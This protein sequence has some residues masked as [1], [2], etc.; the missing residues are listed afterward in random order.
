M[1]EEPDTTDPNGYTTGDRT[2]ET[3][4]EPWV[5][6]GRLPPTSW[7]IPGGTL[8]PGASV[9]TFTVGSA[10]IDG[11][12]RIEYDGNLDTI[13]RLN[14]SGALDITNATVD[15][16]NLTVA[17]LNGGPHIFATYGSLTG[18][19]VCQ[20]ARSAGR[21]QHQLQLPRQPDRTRLRRF[22]QQ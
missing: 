15:F 17:R 22:G 13:D 4:A 10:D 5:V 19:P 7:S 1:A 20:R 18:S 3:T 21:I 6:R 16:D 11:K 8:A 9:G 14:M 2:S 12:L